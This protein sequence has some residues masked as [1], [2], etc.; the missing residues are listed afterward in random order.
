MPEKQYQRQIATGLKTVRGQLDA[1]IRMVE[2][3][4][5]LP[6]VMKQLSAV[7]GSLRR[8]NRLVLRSHL[9]TCVSRAM[10]ERRVEE[11]VEELMEA[12]CL[13]ELATG[14]GHGPARPLDGATAEA[15]ASVRSRGRWRLT[16]RVVS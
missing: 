8:A 10:G 3:E 15:G 14:P 9:E 1:V 7:Q 6:D 13:D 16:R 2:N 5:Y 11:I 4:T 12:L